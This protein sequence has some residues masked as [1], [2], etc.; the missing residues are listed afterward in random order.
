M[1]RELTKNNYQHQSQDVTTNNY[2]HQSQD[3]TYI[4]M[5]LGNVRFRYFIDF[6][7]RIQAKSVM[8]DF[9]RRGI[10]DPR[11]QIYSLLRD[12]SGKYELRMITDEWKWKEL[13]IYHEKLSE[14][15]FYNF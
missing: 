6:K 10:T 5:P 2:Q 7:C 3:V 11:K 1:V 14:N 9:N 12:P 8:D 13:I 4:Y 15:K